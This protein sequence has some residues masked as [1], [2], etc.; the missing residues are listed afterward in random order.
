[1]NLLEQVNLE[2]HLLKARQGFEKSFLHPESLLGK[3]VINNRSEPYVLK[4][5][6]RE[7][8]R[9]KKTWDRLPRKIWQY[10]TSGIKDSSVGNKLCFDN[11]RRAGAESNF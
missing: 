8:P 2:K 11:I 1:M 3:F 4:E 6:V 9:E 5:Y 7:E 10:W